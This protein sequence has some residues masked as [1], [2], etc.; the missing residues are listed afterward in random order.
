MTG[1]IHVGDG[2]H[3]LDCRHS[4]LITICNSCG[5]DPDAPNRR[6]SSHGHYTRDVSAPSALDT[7]AVTKAPVLGTDADVA[8]LGIGGVR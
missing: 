7:L 3:L 6:C 4:R 8:R 5:L 2:V 1:L